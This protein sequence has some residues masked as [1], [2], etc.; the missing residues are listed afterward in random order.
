MQQKNTDMSSKQLEWRLLSALT[1]LI[2]FSLPTQIT[3]Q[4]TLEQ[5]VSVKFPEAEDV[6]APERT[7]AAGKRGI[8][9]TDIV[10]TESGEKSKVDL[11]AVTPKN[12]V[13]T[14]LADQTAVYVYI[15]QNPDKK[16]KFVLVDEETENYLYETNFSLTN[17][18]GIIKISLPKSVKL[19]PNKTYIWQFR[20]ICDGEA[21][22][23]DKF[24]EGFVQRKSLTSEQIT[25]IQQLQKPL[26]KAKLYAE[27][28]IWHET[29]EIL[30][31]QKNSNFQ[32]EWKQLLESV[33]LGEFANAPI[34]N[35][36]N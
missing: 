6:G 34:I 36:E 22:Y 30:T 3:A 9:D 5:Q 32:E 28:G 27:Y 18:V 17:T 8:C 13:I 14:T 20:V 11:I 35:V 33:E 31:A 19:Q 4:T 24:I 1:P 10:T 12:N 2:I 16:A 15:D 21:R 29:L 25:K 7:G 23:K 26:E